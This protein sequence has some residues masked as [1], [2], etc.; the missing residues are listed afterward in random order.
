MVEIKVVNGE[1]LIRGSFDLGYAG[2]YTNEEF[3]NKRIQI[4]DDYEEVLE[5][6]TQGHYSWHVINPYLEGKELNEENVA[7]AISEYYNEVERRVLKCIKQINDNFLIKVFDDMVGCGNEFWDVPN[8]SIKELMPSCQEEAYG[9]VIY[10]PHWKEIDALSKE[11]YRT[12]N[13]NSLEKS[14]VEKRLRKSFPMFNMDGFIKGIRPEI[15]C[16]NGETFSFQ[17]SDSWGKE[18]LCAAYD[19]LDEEFVF[20]DWHNF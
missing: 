7:K 2:T 3:S 10:Q 12:P 8:A 20:T 9:E 18:I 17:C 1:F 5:D 13:N 4:L 16:F 6:C 11:Y 14:D 15:L 19:E